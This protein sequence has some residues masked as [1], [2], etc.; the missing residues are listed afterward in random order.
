MV[1]LRFLINASHIRYYTSYIIYYRSSFIKA[2]LYI[3]VLKLSL[4]YAILSVV[5]FDSV[6]MLIFLQENRIL[7]NL[8][9]WQHETKKI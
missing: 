5:K 3:H 6:L 2:R 9:Q 7:G 8:S 1:L 4:K